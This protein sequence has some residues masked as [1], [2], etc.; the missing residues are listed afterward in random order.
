MPTN[1]SGGLTVDGVPVLGGGGLGLQFGN[2]YF[3]DATNGGDGNDGKSLLTPLK[4]AAQ[5][6]SLAT[7]NKNDVIVLSG[8]ATH[9]LTA[10]FTIK[11]RVHI[12]GTGNF[13]AMSAQSAK[14]SM[15]VTTN[16]LDVTAVNMS[17]ARSTISNV[18]IINNNTL[19]NSISA[20][21]VTCEGG[22]LNNVAVTMPVQLDQTGVNDIIFAG[23]NCTCNNCVFGDD[24]YQFSV[25]RNTMKLG[26]T[27]AQPAKDNYFNNCTWKL[28]TTTAASALISAGTADCV[29]F[30]NTFRGSVLFAYVNAGAGAVAIDAA[31]KMSASTTGTLVFDENTIS[32][33]CTKIS[34]AGGSV[35][36]GVKVCAPVPTAATSGISVTAA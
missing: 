19:A 32:A 21:K 20:L 10:M 6:M 17:G 26:I 25:A 3:V 31:V 23:D 14:L 22:V 35:N 11:D 18:K 24:T 4:T 5:A 30:L 7:A 36:T 33:G 29:N 8:Y 34:V 13:G 1:F 2:Y 28:S 9:A 16:V 12:V 15:G 27:A